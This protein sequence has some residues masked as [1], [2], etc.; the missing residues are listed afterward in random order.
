MKVG[1]AVHRP[2]PAR[3]SRRCQNATRWRLRWPNVL[4]VD[5]VVRPT[6][7]VDWTQV[8][9][10]MLDPAQTPIVAEIAPALGGA[11]DMSQVQRI[12]LEQLPEAFRLQRLVFRAAR[13]A[14]ES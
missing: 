4:R 7:V 2:S 14:F 5:T 12:D 9:A 1:R 3:R 8:P 11:A 10:L 6:L 13:K